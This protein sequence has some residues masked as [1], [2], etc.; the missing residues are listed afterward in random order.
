MGNEYSIHTFKYPSKGYYNK[1]KETKWFVIAL[2]YF[3]YYAIKCDGLNFEI[4]K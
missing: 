1:Y 4:R 2:L 3:I